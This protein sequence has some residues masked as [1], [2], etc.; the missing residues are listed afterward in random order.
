MI[1]W[2]LRDHIKKHKS[3]WLLHC[4]R[5]CNSLSGT[6][7]YIVTQEPWSL[8]WKSYDTCLSRQLGR[9]NS[10]VPWRAYCLV[11]SYDL[12]L[13]C[14]PLLSTFPSSRS[15]KNSW[16]SSLFSFLISSDFLIRA[17]IPSSFTAMKSTLSPIF[18]PTFFS[19]SV[20]K[21]SNQNQLR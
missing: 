18:V 13:H 15:Y 16:L 17:N 5:E 21:L 2:L 20:T 8:P 19:V 10:I 11:K 3:A 14:L 9:V 12:D 6:G 7:R 1:T 4:L